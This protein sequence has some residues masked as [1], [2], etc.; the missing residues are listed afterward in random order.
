MGE[1]DVPEHPSVELVAGDLEHAYGLA[2]EDLPGLG[3]VVDHLV[4]DGREGGFADRRILGRHRSG[5][6]ARKV[7]AIATASG[8]RWGRG[9]RVIRRPPSSN[10]AGFVLLDDGP[11]GVR[12]HRRR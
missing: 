4:R 11:C 5:P 2:G 6:V 7:K 10:S 9:C 12:G 3:Q 1:G 8:R